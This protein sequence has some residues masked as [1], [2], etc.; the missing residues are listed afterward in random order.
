MVVPFEAD[1]TGV[2]ACFEQL[3][4]PLLGDLWRALGVGSKPAATDTLARDTT[5]LAT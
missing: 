2:V 5:R 4:K 1:A 3:R